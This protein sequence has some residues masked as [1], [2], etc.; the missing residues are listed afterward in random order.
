MRH[1]QQSV[2]SSRTTTLR[3]RRLVGHKRLNKRLACCCFCSYATA[4]QPGRPTMVQ[5]NVFDIS[6]RSEDSRFGPPVASRTAHPRA[7]FRRGRATYVAATLSCVLAAIEPARVGAQRSGN[8]ITKTQAQPAHTVGVFE[9]DNGRPIEG[10]QVIDVRTGR[11][12]ITNA[13]GKAYMTY[14]DSGRSLILIRNLGYLE[15]SVYVSHSAHDTSTLAVRLKRITPTLPE[16]VT[17]AARARGSSDT[18]RTLQLN[19]FY[20]RRMTSGAP[21]RAFVTSENI[22]KLSL[23]K[24]LPTVT[25]REIC[26]TNL[27]INGIKVDPPDYVGPSL[28]NPGARAVVAPPYRNGL[29]ALL[30]PSEILAVEMYRVSEVPVRFNPT[31]KGKCGAT[32]VWTR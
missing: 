3:K 31:R 20:E 32:L 28:A 15:Q 13:A 22:E 2:M 10:A 25:G 14:A 9:F 30:H 27:Y 7:R 11:H 1:L 12:A 5:V 24:D 18:I 23:L 21:Y 29:D 17:H 6:C 26:A 4:L 8:D 16:V 19:G